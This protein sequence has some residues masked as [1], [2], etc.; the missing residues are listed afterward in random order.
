MSGWLIYLLVMFL[1]GIILLFKKEKIKIEPLIYFSLKG[2]LKK[3]G[4]EIEFKNKEDQKEKK[5]I[6]PI[7]FALLYQT[8]LGLKFIDSLLN[9]K[10]YSKILK[11]TLKWFGYISII[12]CFVLIA[13]VAY[14]WVQMLWTKFITPD[15]IATA[16][17]MLVLP[18]KVKG[19][20]YVPMAY[21]LISIFIIATVH[22]FGHAILA[23]LHDIQVDSTGPAFLSL[24]IPLIPMA[25]VE[26]NEDKMKAASKRKQLSVIAAG[27]MFN[28][29]AGFLFLLILSVFI[30][31]FTLNIEEYQGLEVWEI[32]NE[33]LISQGLTEGEILIQAYDPTEGGGDIYPLKNN[34][35]LF[36]FLSLFGPG[37]RVGICTKSKCYTSTLIVNPGDPTTA[38]IGI[39]VIENIGTKESIIQKYGSILPTSLL[40]LKG[41][42]SWLVILN[43]GI[44]LF[45]IL[46][47]GMIDEGQLFKVLL[48]DK[49]YQ[50]FIC[51]GLTLFF[52]LLL[53]WSFIIK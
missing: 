2:K 37:D 20:M 39:T 22:E 19:Q 25:F 40:W 13:A 45:N 8:K 33:E 48:K 50:K 16:T 10:I 38:F 1:L 6:F 27:P 21:W 23:R 7:L 11:S 31:P 26:P 52:L 18:F 53:V 17:V 32:D 51:G 46:P 29:V 9:K 42:F 28:I 3:Y 15:A 5:T 4:T 44:G 41:L 12:A 49:K 43:I 34:A 47:I 14:W 36:N 35:E 30:I 24:I